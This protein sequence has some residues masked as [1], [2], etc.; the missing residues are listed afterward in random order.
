MTTKEIKDQLRASHT[1]LW[2][3]CEVMDVASRSKNLPGKWSAL[4]HLRHVIKGI[5]AIKGYLMQDKAT[6]ANTFGVTDRPSRSYRELN[7][8]YLKRLSEGVVSTPRFSPE[9]THVISLETERERGDRCVE[10]IIAAMSNWSD[11]ELDKYLCPHPT[12]GNLTAREMI[13]FAIIHA[14][15]HGKGVKGLRADSAS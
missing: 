5:E 13:Y 14:E 3:E 10:D 2:K 1:A 7:E 4:Q 11:A 8:F 9:D 6:I 12:I 15:H